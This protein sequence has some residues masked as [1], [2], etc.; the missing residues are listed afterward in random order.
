V[1][2]Y[3]TDQPPKVDGRVDDEVWRNA[4]VI[5][6]LFQREPETGKPATERTEIFMCYDA[7]DVY[8]GFRCYDDPAG[9]TAKEM[10]RDISL[11]FD[12]RVQ[13]ILTPF[14]ISGPGFGSKSVRVAQ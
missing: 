6:Q 4:T 10:A 11:S 13:I 5:D 8:F 14:W 3:F 7:E 12:D 9:I 1:Q 2:A